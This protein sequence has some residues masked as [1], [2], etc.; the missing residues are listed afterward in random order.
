MILLGRKCLINS[1]GTGTHQPAFAGAGQAVEELSAVAK[2]SDAAGAVSW[3]SSRGACKS[4]SG[5]LALL[6][7]AASSG[8]G[9]WDRYEGGR[10]SAGV[11]RRFWHP[12]AKAQKLSSHPAALFCLLR[13]PLT[14]TNLVFS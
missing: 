12:E 7:V 11:T 14:I 9:T 8:V 1:G 13:H 5:A 4:C 3:P 2:V 6:T 10:V